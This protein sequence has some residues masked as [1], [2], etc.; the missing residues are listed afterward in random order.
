MWALI[1]SWFT[2]KALVTDLEKLG[3]IIEN[4]STGDLINITQQVNQA[5][6]GSKQIN[7]NSLGIFIQA[8]KVLVEVIEAKK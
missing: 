3:Q 6:G 8:V 4:T 2:R 1:R 7:V 5:L